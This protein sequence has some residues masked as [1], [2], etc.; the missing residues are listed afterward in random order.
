M[1]SDRRCCILCIA[2][3]FEN[4][5]FFC[6]YCNIIHETVFKTGKGE[7]TWLYYAYRLENQGTE[8]TGDIRGG[9]GGP[10]HW[11]MLMSINLIIFF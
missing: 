5:F 2:N 6:F 1:S 11:L 9:I 3:D 8:S 7:G 4:S 10:P